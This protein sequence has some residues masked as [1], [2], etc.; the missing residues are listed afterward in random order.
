MRL[1]YVRG[2]S[3][4]EGS[5]EDR[6]RDEDAEGRRFCAGLRAALPRWSRDQALRIPRTARRHRVLRVRLLQYL[7][8]RSARAERA[9]AAL[10]RGQGPGRGH[11]LRLRVHAQGLGRLTWR[12]RVPAVLRLLAPRQGHAGVWRIQRG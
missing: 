4:R 3:T 2:T 1:V 8:Q 12:R 6:K 5:D 9:P 7:K 10:R 11:L